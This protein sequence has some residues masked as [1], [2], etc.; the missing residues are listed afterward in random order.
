MLSCSDLCVLPSRFEGLGKSIAETLATGTPLVSTEV[1]G[2][3]EI[4][5]S[6]KTGLLVEPTENKLAEA[7][8]FALNNPEKMEQMAMVGKKRIQSSLSITQS[9]HAL[10]KIY[11]EVR[12]K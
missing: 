3:P 4:V 8:L 10:L 9:C 7:I 12:G 2:I 11:E 1:G 6:G 5:E